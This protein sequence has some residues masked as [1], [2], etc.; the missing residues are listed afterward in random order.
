MSQPTVDA[1]RQKIQQLEEELALARRREREQAIKELKWQWQTTMDAVG[2]SICVLDDQWHIMQCNRATLDLIGKPADEI[3]G[4]RCFELIHDTDQPPINCPVQRL[5]NTKKR[6]TSVLHYRDRWIEVAAD[7]ILDEAHKLKGIVHVISDITDFKTAEE[8]IKKGERTLRSL[9][10][11]A[12]TGIGMTV[13]RII[14]Q[15]NNKLSDMVGYSQNELIGKSARLLH[16]TDEDYE[17]VGREKYAQIEASG[18]GTVETRWRHKDGRILDILLSSTPL[19]KADLSA[20]VTFTALDITE[21]KGLEKDLSSIFD[22]SLAMICTADIKTATFTKINPAFTEILGYPREELLHRPF[23]EFV[24]PQ[25]LQPTID[26]IEEKL[27]KG[28]KVV[29]FENRYRCKDGDYRW[30]SWV[31]HPD[32]D[33]GVTYAVG[34]DITNHK[35]AQLELAIFKSAVEASSDAIGLSTPEGKH[36]Y[37]NKAFSDLFG[38]VGDDPPAS[39]YVDKKLGRHIFHTLMA[40]GSWSGEVEM[41]DR[42]GKKV[43]ILLRAYALK[44]TAG[45]VANLVGV[46]TD[47]GERKR[48]ERQLRRSEQ[49]FRAISEML[50][51]T[52]FEMDHSGRLTFVNNNALKVFG[53]SYKDF[54]DGLYA[55]DLIAPEDRQKAEARISSILQGHTGSIGRRYSAVRKDGTTFPVLV[56]SVRGVDEIG[57]PGMRGI[58]IDISEQEK[59]ARERDQ[60]EEQY[61]QA[62]KM[63][64]VGR[65]AGGIAHDLN[66]MLSPI[67]GYGELLLAAMGPESPNRQ[68]I[69][70]MHQAGQRARDLVQQLLAFSRKQALDIQ[71]VNLVSVL[72]GFEGF[73]NR[74]LR[75]DIQ[76]ELK[77]SEEIPEILADTG[78]IEQVIM[79]LAVNAQDAM[80]DGG[81]ITIEAVMTET[82]GQTS[83]GIGTAAEEGPFVALVVSDTGHGMDAQTQERIFDPFF[84]TKGQGKGTGLGLATVYGIVKQH[85]G[86]IRVS[87]EPGKGARFQI[88]FP[89][90]LSKPQKGLV[91]AMRPDDFHGTENI[92]IVEDNEGVRVLAETILNTNGY[93]T[94]AAASGRECLDLLAEKPSL[95]LMLSDV[96]LE[97]TNGKELFKQVQQRYSNIK[98][99]YMSG[100][101]DDVIVHHG[102]LEEGIAF[103]QKPFSILGLLKKVRQVLDEG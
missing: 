37:Q 48:F 67:L 63:E 94:I 43:D 28:Q 35:R 25:D 15:A 77:L 100:Y 31:S 32:T 27:Q 1:L 22:R 92:L 86:S 85:N 3:V 103:I 30:I 91:D 61:I 73:L 41:Y 18:T 54:E 75:E 71:S 26:V 36:W 87:S 70:Q 17:D 9:F 8:E 10:E 33:R 7:P 53:Y 56:Y 80:P 40:G 62:Q 102:V 82:C 96:V 2:V 38:D 51:Q 44:D 58:I 60:F 29:H 69:E 21:R 12:P 20:G 5:V 84:T 45:Q 90:A 59:L 79:N 89:A 50:P 57:S 39:V 11:A 101:T 83:Y 99:I 72:E 47:I 93:Q 88:F 23:L 34:Y 81:K 16:E 95:D 98:V 74:L 66:N 13:N 64:A 52:V 19:D 49:R 24:H 68:A 55:I 97:D 6:E 14:V 4:K 65:L 78:Q 46:H 42:S 76:L